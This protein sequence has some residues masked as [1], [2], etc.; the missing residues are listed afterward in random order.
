M[1][2]VPREQTHVVAPEVGGKLQAPPANRG[3]EKRVRRGRLDIG[4]SLDLHGYTRHTARAA[5]HHFLSAA[6][7]RGDAVVV[8]VT[9]VGR[10]GE[11]VLRQRLPEWLGDPEIRPVV[12][13]FAQAHRMHGGAGAYY[14][15]LKRPSR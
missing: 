7:A 12:S 5:L 4:A 15:F 2:R 8:V 13:G 6:Q 3:T 10:A 9:G 11:G 14:V 1:A